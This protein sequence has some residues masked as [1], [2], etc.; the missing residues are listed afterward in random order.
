MKNAEEIKWAL[1]HEEEYDF[2]IEAPKTKDKQGKPK[3]IDTTT[4]DGLQLKLEIEQ[5][6]KN[7][8]IYKSNKTVAYGYIIRQCTQAMKNELEARED[9]TIIKDNMIG[10]LK[11][12]KEITHNYQTSKYYIGTV[13]K[14]IKD[15]FTVKQEDNKP[16]V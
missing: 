10:T 8:N 1:K 14:V 12:I 7:K 16:T 6:I 4:A 11:A 13:S 2:T 15:F 3:S 5:H 9:W